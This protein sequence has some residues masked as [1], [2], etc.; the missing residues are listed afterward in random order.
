MLFRKGFGDRFCH[1]DTPVITPGTPTGRR[2]SEDFLVQ[3][4]TQRLVRMV[5]T[6]TRFASNP[7]QSPNSTGKT[8]KRGLGMNLNRDSKV[9]AG[10]GPGT[11][12]APTS[13]TQLPQL[14][15]QG[16]TLLHVAEPG[17]ETARGMEGVVQWK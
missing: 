4:E 7:R 5:K 2:G 6:P 15:S 13:V 17:A 1:R 11:K 16:L 12:S 14:H 8:V 3:S 9:T 10:G